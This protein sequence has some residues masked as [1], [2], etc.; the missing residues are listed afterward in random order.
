MHD[1]A[2]IPSPDGERRAV[3]VPG[4]SPAPPGRAATD[5]AGPVLRTAR[6]RLAPV[7]AEDL[8]EL[9]ALHADPRAFADDTTAPLTEPAQMRWVLARWREGWDRDGLGQ[10]TVRDLGP[11]ARLLGVVG[12]SRLET[13]QGALL[14]A[15]WRLSPAA[16]GRGVA[17]EA[18]RAVLAAPHLGGRGEEI[19]AITAAGNRRSRALAARLGFVPAPA[20][21]PV[22]GGRDGDLLLVRPAPRPS[23]P[24]S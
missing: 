16:T 6:L 2:A 13:E 18:M 1:G 19:V 20:G 22:P 4:V 17:S 9:F 24:G 23:G 3:V 11:G 10:L 15:Y 8:E 12:L 21:R 5:G 14:N 7:V